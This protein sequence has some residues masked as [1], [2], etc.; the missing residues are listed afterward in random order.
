MSTCEKIVKL[1]RAVDTMLQAL[2]ELSSARVI[3]ETDDP[4]GQ[5]RTK[6]LNAAQQLHDGVITP[7]D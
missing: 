5:L 6:L 1:E 2:L 7:C 4:M 3:K